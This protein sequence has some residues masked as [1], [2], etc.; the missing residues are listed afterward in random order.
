[1]LSKS[2]QVG[3]GCYMHCFSFRSTGLLKAADALAGF[4]HLRVSFGKTKNNQNRSS[5]SPL[6]TA[7]Q[8]PH[9]QVFAADSP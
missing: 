8:V 1:M 5:I 7:G 6:K 3:I 2:F 4:S 9:V